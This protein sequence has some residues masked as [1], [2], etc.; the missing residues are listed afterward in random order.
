MAYRFGFSRGPGGNNRLQ[1]HGRLVS[2][3]ANHRLGVWPHDRRAQTE[4][5]VSGRA[6]PV[7]IGALHSA[8]PSSE[9]IGR[10]G[11]LQWR[12]DAQVVS[13]FALGT[14]LGGA[15]IS[16]EIINLLAL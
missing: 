1:F 3:A 12:A 4:A 2:G 5:L 6:T 13:W 8:A 15:Y 10:C 14:L 16:F 7:S 9:G 11:Q